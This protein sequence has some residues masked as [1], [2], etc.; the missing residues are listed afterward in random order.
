MK[1][2]LMNFEKLAYFR[3]KNW[4]KQFNNSSIFRGKIN[5]TIF[6]PVKLAK[7]CVKIRKM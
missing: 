5:N 6:V 3:L 1:I 4:I 7:I 2:F